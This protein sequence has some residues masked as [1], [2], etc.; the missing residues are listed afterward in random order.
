MTTFLVDSSVLLDLVTADPAWAGW[1]QQQLDSAL[2]VGRIVLT[3]VAYAEIA[4]AFPRI[5]TLD[6]AIQEMRLEY[7]EM[8]RPALFLAARVAQAYRR[9][10]GQQRSVL[11]DFLIGAHASVC[12][13]TLITRDLRR[14][15][16]FPRLATITPPP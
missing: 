2:S 6:H 8:P 10:G 9:Q 4:L 14:R 13:Y 15:R 1:S 3:P 5:E 12:G 7:E 16:Y 11:P